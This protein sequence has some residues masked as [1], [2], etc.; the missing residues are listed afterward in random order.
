MDRH[1]IKPTSL[2]MIRRI[3]TTSERSRLMQMTHT[4]SE[5]LSKSSCNLH[6]P[7]SLPFSTPEEDKLRATDCASFL[8]DKVTKIKVT[9]KSK[10]NDA[11]SNPL[12]GDKPFIGEKLCEVYTGLSDQVVTHSAAGVNG[13]GSNSPVA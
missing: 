2:L 10:F 13:S 6:L 7:D 12:Q 5:K 4:E 9:I 1:A 8:H 11:L 3:R